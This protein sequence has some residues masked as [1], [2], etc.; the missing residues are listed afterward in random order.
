MRSLLIAPAD[1]QRLAEALTSGADA[2]VVDLAGAAPARR[3]GARAAATRFLKEARRQGG[4]PALIVRTHAVDSGETD[5]DLDEA[6]AGAPDAILLPG[7]LGAASVQQLS[8]KLAVRE[9][10][11]ALTDGE[12]RIIAVADTA[13][14]LFQMEGYRGSSAR[15]IG[16]AWSAEALRADI[17][18]ET[19][20]DHLG[21]ALGPYRL[22]RELTLLAATSARVAAI[23]TAFPN[24]RDLGGLRAEALAARRDGFTG[25]IALDPAQVDVINDVFPSRSMS[26]AKGS[27]S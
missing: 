5:A 8:A 15:L 13:Q 12:T 21:G 14:S 26:I 23:D 4:G 27:R 22:A 24:I 18:A 3:A 11:F 7:S 2:I 20:R 17:G 6:M 16:I 25:K 10:K 9:A 1:E 19:G